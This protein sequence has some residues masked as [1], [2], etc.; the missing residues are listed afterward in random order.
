M[1]H[2][3]GLDLSAANLRT[4][5]GGKIT[6]SAMRPSSLGGE[7]VNTAAPSPRNTGKARSRCRPAHPAT[8]PW[9]AAT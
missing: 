5:P 7:L 8:A 2:G 1:L 9:P 6:S 4:D 3:G